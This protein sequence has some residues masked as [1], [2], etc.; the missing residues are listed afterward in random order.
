MNTNSQQRAELFEIAPLLELPMLELPLLELPMLELPLLEPTK[1][2]RALPDTEREPCFGA[3]EHEVDAAR[4][5]RCQSIVDEWGK[6]HG[7][8]SSQSFWRYSSL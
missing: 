8:S 3:I 2:P 1:T 7:N 4:R 6:D 5:R